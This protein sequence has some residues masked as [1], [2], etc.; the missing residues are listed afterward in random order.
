M[1]R[2]FEGRRESLAGVAPRVAIKIILPEHAKDAGFQRMF[3]NEAR[4]G[5]LLQHQNLVQIQDF[6]SEDDRYY[7]VME[8]VEGVTM[9]RAVSM[10]KRAETPIPMT[11][12]AE[13]GRQVCDGL[14]YAHTAKDE[15]GNSI[16]LIHRDIKPS[17]L[18]LNPQGVVKILDFG[19]S[20][21]W[22]NNEKRG[23][24]RGTWGYM[25]PEQAAGVEVGVV[26]DLFGLAAV[27]YEM[28]AGSAL[29]P[30]K[31]PEELRELMLSDS[32]ARRASQLPQNMSP[33]VPV[34]IRALQRD[35]SAR[36]A[37]AAEMGRALAKLVSDPVSA[38]D[39]LVRFQ[40]AVAEGAVS[41][42]NM[43]S[44]APRSN[45]STMSRTIK[46]V[47]TGAEASGQQAQPSGV[48]GLPVGVGGGI[49]PVAGQLDA[50][51]QVLSEPEED[52]I[53][54]P[55]VAG[56]GVGVGML[57]V[58]GLVLYQYQSTPVDTPR[59]EVPAPVVEADQSP[60]A[61]FASEN[62]DAAKIGENTD[63]NEGAEAAVE[64]VEVETPDVSEDAVVETIAAPT[65]AATAASSPQPTTVPVTQQSAQSQTVEEPT[66]KATNPTAQ[67]ASSQEVEPEPVADTALLTVSAMPRAKV[68]IDGQ[69]RRYSPVYK[70]ELPSGVHVVTLIADDGRQTSFDVE[71]SAGE[72]VRR[73]WSFEQGA[74]IGQ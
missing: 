32:G 19:I 25:S 64:S 52:G 16:R 7:L 46:S 6:D 60:W 69:F 70:L 57:F 1:A 13:V 24:V 40:H 71:L 28:A 22:T 29:F 23:S 33:L 53:W 5:S 44:G 48:S 12:I 63:E 3:I 39:R 34:L 42:V 15:E 74:F 35:P 27:L 73:V 17:N 43:A 26:S 14:E 38:R 55:V 10:C 20:K 4:H 11:V 36:F 21:G 66:P 47:V 65:G 2:V 9:R 8:Y 30:E 54:W 56:V 67:S 18:M 68:L 72:S 51:T 50:A 62:A 61:D 31:K 41:G 49:A 45:I 59:P 37:S 58:V